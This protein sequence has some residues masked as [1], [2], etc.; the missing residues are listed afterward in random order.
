MRLEI[1]TIGDELLLGIRENTHLTYFGKQFARYGQIIQRNIVIRD[2]PNHIESY[3]R[4]SMDNSDI[5]ITTGGLGPTTDDITRETVAQVL[6]LKL[7]HDKEAEKAI[8]TRF[9]SMGRDV[10]ENN[11]R[12]AKKP[13][14]AEIIT[15]HHGTAPGLWLQCE[16]RII[17]MLPGP[18]HELYPMFEKQV[19]PRLQSENVISENE[20]YLQLRTIGVGESLLENN[21][22][23]IFNRHPGKLL[24]SYCA[25]SGLVDLRLSPIDDLLSWKEI[26]AIGDECKQILGDDF[27]CY[28]DESL[29][30]LVLNQL[31]SLGKTLAI[32]ESCT[33]GLLSNAFTDVPGSSKTFIGGFIC[34]TNGT[35]LQMLNI[36]EMI[37]QQYGAVSAECAVAMASGTAERLSTDYA[38][39]ITGYAGPDGGNKENPVGTVYIGYHSPVEVR[40]SKIVFSGNRLMI[41][42]RAVSAALDLLRRKLKIV[43]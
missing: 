32:A 5:V 7:I 28:G 33:G 34:Y 11:L 26:E 19:V 31:S 16:G 40:S 1:I 37:L 29:S 18:P 27:I 15:N 17:I 14:G 6:G 10:T 8:R 24:V 3:F 30:S 9:R 4:N 43:N 38:L 2:D 22:Q 20:Y 41:K 35:K 21:L 42:S 12:Q 23:H 39:S 25:H 13:I 36:P